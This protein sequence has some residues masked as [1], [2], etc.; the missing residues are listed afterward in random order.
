ML[1][2]LITKTALV[3][4]RSR[5]RAPF[6]NMIPSKN[7]SL[8]NRPEN[9]SSRSFKPMGSV[10]FATT[11][12]MSASKCL[13][14]ATAAAAHVNG[15]LRSPTSGSREKVSVCV[16]LW[17]SIGARRTKLLQKK[18]KQENLKKEIAIKTIYLNPRKK[19]EKN[20]G[21]VGVLCPRPIIKIIRLT[22]KVLNWRRLSHVMS[23]LVKEH[24][25][26]CQWPRV[27]PSK[28]SL[29]P[30]CRAQ[31]FFTPLKQKRNCPK[32][33]QIVLSKL[34]VMKWAWKTSFLRPKMNFQPT[35]IGK[36]QTFHPLSQT[37][38]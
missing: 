30:Q 32:R 15:T 37:I 13:Y 19:S 25:F 33:L 6:K 26:R 38:P 10:V 12:A 5:Q 22:I 36:P 20:N 3:L 34:T 23:S 1:R 29:T 7:T 24:R 17:I 4:S 8:S 14:D 35:E 2:C 31:S 9:T 18:Q 27:R 16:L 28:T 11:K 21:L